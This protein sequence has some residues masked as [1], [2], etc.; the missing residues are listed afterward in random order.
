MTNE[1][2]TIENLVPAQVFAYGG[3]QNVLEE[4]TAWARSLDKDASTEAG[5][6]TIR[7]AAYKISRSKTALD[8]LGKNL[9]DEYAEKIKPI[10]AERKRIRDTLDSLA[11]EVRKPLT[12]YENREKARQE[13]HETAINAIAALNDRTFQKSEEIKHELERLPVL[14]K[15]DWEEY[16]Q[17]AQ[18]THD[19]V[20][21]SLTGQFADLKKREEEK[22]ELARLRAEKE[23]RERLEREERIRQEASDKAK[24]DAEERAERER[25][26]QERRHREEQERAERKHREEQ[27]LAERE[28]KA[29]EERAAESEREKERA[30]ERERQRAE[31]EKR[32]LDAEEKRRAENKAHQGKINKEVVSALIDI[33]HPALTEELAKTI[34]IAIAKGQIPHVKISY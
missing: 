31:E 28:K 33:D 15:R 1:L 6:D 29:A 24:R 25:Q 21:K 26:E 2:V 30:V 19:L 20:H 13:G 4:I 9:K 22:E 11:D 32:R 5:R 18:E 10:D 3:A 12:D 16:G 27:E 17:R 23:E 14:Y 8:A 34:V 7:S